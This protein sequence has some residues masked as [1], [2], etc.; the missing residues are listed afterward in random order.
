MKCLGIEV[1][2]PFN[3]PARA[4]E[5]AHTVPSTLGGNS[6]TKSTEDEKGAIMESIAFITGTES[7]ISVN[8]G[9][10]G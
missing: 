7:L 1:V 6:D 9:I 4:E 5:E 10:N 3:F 8:L 2:N